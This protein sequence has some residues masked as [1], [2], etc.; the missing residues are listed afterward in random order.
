MIDRIPD[1]YA[2][3]GLNEAAAAD[4]GEDEL[5][6]TGGSSGGG[7]TEG[8]GQVSGGT[9]D[10]ERSMPAGTAHGIAAEAE[11]LGHPEGGLAGMGQRS[12][13]GAEPTGAETVG[14]GAGRGE[15]GSGTAKDTGDLGGGGGGTG[16][17]GTD[18]PNRR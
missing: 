1:P 16:P 5:G 14:A 3:E 7:T 17:A 9:T 6:G 11:A 10:R 12:N 2:G 4:L 13:A 18:G 8:K 15:P